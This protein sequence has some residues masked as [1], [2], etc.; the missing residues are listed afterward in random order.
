[1]TSSEQGNSKEE[2]IARILDATFEVFTEFS[3]EDATTGEIAS[4]ARISKRDLYAFFPTKQALLMGAI[5]R[6]MQRQ[7]RTFREVIDRT[8]RLRSL[9]SKLVA[10]G[11]AIVEDIFS[12]TMAVTRR[13]V[14][15]ESIKQPFLGD[16]FFEGGVAQRCRL[17]GEVLA[18]NQKAS[19][20][21]AKL[22]AERAA[23]RYVSMV[24]YF[25]STMTEVGL[26]SEWTEDAIK[27][28]V[29]EETDIFLKAHSVFT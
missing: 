7:D 5:V 10:I 14:V 21:S 9:R 15:S 3:F 8:A 11:I 26:R 18:A 19:S 20:S 13:L 24:A 1:M 16:L 17:I 28:H 29:T 23:Q 25:P 2:R 22:A 12:P 4:R 27:K 6:E